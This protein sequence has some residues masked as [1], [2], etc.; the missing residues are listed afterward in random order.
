MQNC[1]GV[2]L[3]EMSSEKYGSLSKTRPAYMLPYGGRYRLIDFTLSNMANNDFS[4]VLL[5]AGTNM[6]STLDHVGNGKPWELNRRRS[7]LVIFPSKYNADERD[8]DEIEICYNTLPFYENAKEETIYFV[9]PM[10]IDKED[11]TEPYEKYKE[12][13]YDV[14]LFYKDIEDSLGKYIGERKLIFNNEG[15]LSNIGI[16][17]GTEEKFSMLVRLGFVKKDIFIDIIKKTKE[18][19]SEKKLVDAIANKIGKLKVG[20]YKQG[21]EIE[22]IRDLKDFYESSMRLLDKDKYNSIFYENGVV[23]T[24]SKDEP[25]ARYGETS[26][27]SNSLVANG[28]I[29]EGQVENS[30]IFRG[31][32]IEKDAIVKNSILFEN[33]VIE[34][35]AV[36]INVITDK[37][38][39]IKEGVSL[40]GSYDNPYVIEKN[41]VIER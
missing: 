23:L 34:K 24:K 41:L 2:I 21:E 6:R 30:I 32:T 5:Y 35:D 27:V 3:G 31:V 15:E 16:N 26:N 37:L 7:G 8:I 25:S 4:N 38:V 19:R 10:I 36:V 12:E 40:V 1:I 28:C 17:L 11:L 22:I 20:L 13:D 18:N 14:L 39:T 29:I 9:D 33:T